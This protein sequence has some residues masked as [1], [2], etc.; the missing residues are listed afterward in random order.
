MIEKKHILLGIKAVVAGNYRDY[1]D[2]IDRY[3]AWPITLDVK[4]ARYQ[5]L[6]S[7]GTATERS[8]L[9]A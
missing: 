7:T 3:A 5:W 8:Q 2:F 9:P 6:E 4:L 1:G